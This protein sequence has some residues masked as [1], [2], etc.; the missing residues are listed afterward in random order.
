M[1]GAVIQWLRTRCASSPSPRTRSTTR[2]RL[3]DTGGVY[4]VPA[5]TGLGAPHWDMYARGCI[6]GITPR[7]QEGAHHPRGAGVDC[8][9]ELRP[10]QG[11]GAGHRPQDKRAEGGRR[12]KPGRLFDAVP[13]GHFGLR[14][15]PARCDRPPGGPPRWARPIWRAWRSASGRTRGDPQPV[16]L[17]R[18]LLLR[19]EEER[20]KKLL[21]GWHKAVGRSL[22]WAEE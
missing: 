6:I 5:F 17:R 4:L 11:D 3:E 21:H 7:H 19:M 22:G 14:G 16:E 9:P 18:D 12:R 1:G 20:R 2:R 8:L 10:G 13:G 15:P